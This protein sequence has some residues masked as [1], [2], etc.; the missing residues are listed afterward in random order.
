MLEGQLKPLLR[1]STI[2]FRKIAGS[3]QQPFGSAGTQLK[4]ARNPERP[5][6]HQMVDQ[7]TLTSRLWAMLIV[8]VS[9]RVFEIPSE[10]E[11]RSLVDGICIVSAIG[12]L[13]HGPR[14]HGR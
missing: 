5:F 13:S 1:R 4:V 10:I 9:R 7:G 12:Q 8:S 11:H 14:S 3:D 6:N 2:S